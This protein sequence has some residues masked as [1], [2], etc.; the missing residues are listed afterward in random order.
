ML[1]LPFHHQ[2]AA[3]FK[4]H[5][6]DLLRFP[7]LEFENTFCTKAN[8]G[9]HW[10]TPKGLFIIAMPSHPFGAIVIEIQET[11]IEYMGALMLDPLLDK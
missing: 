7:V 5:G 3:I 1:G 6:N 11:R 2:K 9:N 4:K 10:I 8:G